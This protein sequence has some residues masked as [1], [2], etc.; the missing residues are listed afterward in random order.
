MDSVNSLTTLCAKRADGTVPVMGV[1]RHFMATG[2][3]AMFNP[4]LLGIDKDQTITLDGKEYFLSLRKA[5]KAKTGYTL[6]TADY[7][8]LELRILAALAEERELIEIFNRGE[9]PF[10]LIA[11]KL[12]RKD[13]VTEFERNAAKQVSALLYETV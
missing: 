1:Y 8:Q 6:V 3:V 2:R 10:R 11:S 12:Y 13:E 5:L 7:C 4:N 9:D